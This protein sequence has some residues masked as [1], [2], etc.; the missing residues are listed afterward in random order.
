MKRALLVLA[1]LTACGA[2]GDE[3][4]RSTDVEPSILL[5]PSLTA[6]SDRAISI[7]W[8]TSF[9]VRRHSVEYGTSEALGEVA[10]LKTQTQY[11]NVTLDGLL[12]ATTYYY[13]VASAST[14]SEVYSFRTPR[15]EGPVSLV[16]FADN[17][18]GARTF[19]K[20]TVPL[21]EELAPD[22][23]ISAGDL[24]GDGK[25]PEHWAE[26]LYEPGRV[27]WRTIPW[28]PVRGNHDGETGLAHDMMPVPNNSQWYART[29]GPLRI[30]VLDT[31]VDYV[32]G[33]PQHEW[34]ETEMGGDAWRRAPF[35]VVSFHKPPF[36]ALWLSPEYDGE[37][38]AR[39]T[40]VPMFEA[41][42]ADL[43]I[44]G[45]THGYEHGSRARTDGGATHYLVT[46][47]A[48]GELDT[49]R[50]FRWSHIQRSISRHNIVLMTATQK[51]LD[52][53]VIDPLNEEM[54]DAFH[55]SSRP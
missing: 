34:L 2:E 3:A 26:H 37:A 36:T 1:F 22:A 38:A 23:L 21:I 27:L 9:E 51:R 15:V 47:G 13:R 28:F 8:Q 17:Q 19:G 4:G 24:V 31:N 54:L 10:Q 35:R 32:S 16:L 43:V 45:H 53:K 44:S 40:L 7:W 48:G 11:P 14:A 55:I 50:V 52:F 25:R 5:G 18:E 29:Y 39:S 6:P 12:P 41:N 46:G 42:R 49:I 33:S 20:F 30:V